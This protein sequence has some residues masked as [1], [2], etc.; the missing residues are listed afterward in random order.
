MAPVINSLQQ[1][2]NAATA[3]DPVSP[4]DAS[5]REQMLPQ[6]SGTVGRCGVLVSHVVGQAAAHFLHTPLHDLQRHDA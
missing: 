5:F 6:L 2:I 4:D 3:T 1:H